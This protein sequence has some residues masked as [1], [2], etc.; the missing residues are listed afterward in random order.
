MKE[1]KKKSRKRK[2]K[3]DKNFENWLIVNR[4]F[5]KILLI[6]KDSLIPFDHLANEHFLLNLKFGVN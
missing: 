2:L 1:R 6:I 5:I 4:E 3:K